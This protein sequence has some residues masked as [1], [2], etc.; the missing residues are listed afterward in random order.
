M[1]TPF[2]SVVSPVY[3]A[4]KMLEELVGQIEH[5]IKSITDNY[6][7][8]L[9]ED[10]GPDNSWEVIE[11]LCEK[12]KK[13]IGV[14]LSRNFGQ[15]Y[16]ITAGLD[17]CKGDWIFVMDCDLQDRPDQMNQLYQKALEGYDI[18]QGRRENR[19]DSFFKKSFSKCFYKMLAY[20]SGY[21]QDSTIANYGIYNKKVI[22]SIVSMRETIRFFPTMVAWV[23]YKKTSIE[24]EHSHRS[25]GKSSYTFKKLFNLA[26]D[27]IL[28]YSD[29]PLR[30]IIKLGLITSCLS[31]I[32]LL[33]NLYKYFTGEIIVMGY[34]SLII[35]IW[36]L[37]GLLML[38]MGVVGLYVG[39]TFEST[40]NRPIYIIDKRLN[41]ND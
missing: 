41:T 36:F 38:M 30:L 15:H 6:E 16:A 13:V 28:A 20:L 12:N 26:L 27:I 17:Q 19:K 2:I 37:S 21:T 1:K 39:K 18:V 40:K 9:V 25:E 11:K 3:R 7:I 23:G 4:E 5:E 24:I 8:I 22:Q 32:Y 33:Y 29:K 14:K 10:C 34:M 35:S 31:F